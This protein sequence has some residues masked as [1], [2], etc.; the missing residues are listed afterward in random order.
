MALKIN[1]YRNNNQ[2]SKNYG[3]VYGRVKNTSPQ[4][5]DFLAA[6]MSEHNTP[7]SKGVIKGILTDAVKCIKELILLGQPIKLA[8]L[9]IFSAEITSS[10]A[11]TAKDYDLRKNVKT[12]RMLAK[13]TG[14][15][16]RSEMTK[17]GF[18]EFTDLAVAVRDG[19]AELPTGSDDTS[20]DSGS[21]S[22]EPDVRP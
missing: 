20:G 5:V 21:G 19:Q 7:F 14:A 9:A 10:G 3:Q 2:K 4:D 1:L 8:D 13:A 6:H 12:V 18:L 16:S 22:D 17:D 11:D 15:V